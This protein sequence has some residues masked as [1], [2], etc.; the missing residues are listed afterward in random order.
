METDTKS[1]A[2]SFFASCIISLYILL[3]SFGYVLGCIIH[4]MVLLQ[5]HT[6]WVSYPTKLSPLASRQLGY[7]GCIKWWF[8]SDPNVSTFWERCVLKTSQNA[9]ISAAFAQNISGS[10][11]IKVANITVTLLKTPLPARHRCWSFLLDLDHQDVVNLPKQHQQKKTP[12]SLRIA[13]Q[14]CGCFF[15]INPQCL[16]HLCYL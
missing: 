8:S 5:D 12:S 10:D 7:S 3:E 16:W 14:S 9:E 11:V 13:F 15:Q 4:P 1:S 6:Q 2:L